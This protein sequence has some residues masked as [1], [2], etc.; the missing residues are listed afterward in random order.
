MSDF[1]L[2]LAGVASDTLTERKKMRKFDMVSNGLIGSEAFFVAIEEIK[3][4]NQT[5]T[6]KT[7]SQMCD[8]HI[9][10]AGTLIEMFVHSGS[11][12]D[13]GEGSFKRNSC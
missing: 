8:I 9:D 2:L 13:L 12:I 10:T 4:I 11:V 1:I 7:L 3:R 5:F 6:N